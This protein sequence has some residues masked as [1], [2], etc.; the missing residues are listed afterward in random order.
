LE[1]LAD[2]QKA[3][4]GILADLSSNKMPFHRDPISPFLKQIVIV[5]SNAGAPETSNIPMPTPDSKPTK[6]KLPTPGFD[7][8]SASIFQPYCIRCHEGLKDPAFVIKS[9]DK[10]QGAIASNQMPKF[11]PKP[12]PDS[13]KDLLTAWVEAKMPMGFDEVKQ[14]LFV[15]YCVR[16]HGSFANYASVAK[17]SLNIWAKVWADDMPLNGD[18]VPLELKQLL[19]NWVKQG[20]PN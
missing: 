14:K 17:N 2:V 5:W 1:R 8:V 18:P 6:P 12:L 4:P 10:I 3:L 16:C 7:Q 20:T 13:L 19:D 11:S 15:P 9:I